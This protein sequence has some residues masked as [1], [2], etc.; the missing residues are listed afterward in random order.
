MKMTFAEAVKSGIKNYSNFKGTATR[1]E[2]W[3]FYLFTVLLNMVTT[4][5]DSFISPS[6]S[7]SLSMSSGGPLYTFTNLVLIVPNLS[8]AFRRFHD[9]GFSAKWLGLWLVPI[10]AFFAG[11]GFLLATQPNLNV[12]T[13]SSEQLLTAI[14]PLLPAFLLALAVGIFQLV[15]NLKATKGA[16]QGNRYAVKAEAETSAPQ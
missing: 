5:I 9:A 14:L 12:E 11:G 3:Y 16:G 2:F 7:G 1:T 10:I 8:L 13:A 6:G 4:T 15:V